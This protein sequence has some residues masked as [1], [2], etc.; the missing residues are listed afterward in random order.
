MNRTPE[1]A[2]RATMVALDELASELET[3][4]PDRP[5]VMSLD[6]TFRAFISDYV[7]PDA[8][9][10]DVIM[11]IGNGNYAAAANGS[12]REIDHFRLHADI[13]DTIEWLQ[14]HLNCRRCTPSPRN[15]PRTQLP[16]QHRVSAP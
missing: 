10:D 1:L 5:R 13:I 8:D 16:C 11:I 6:A 15:A 2:V 7:P 3:A 4:G 12:V 9:T 14:L